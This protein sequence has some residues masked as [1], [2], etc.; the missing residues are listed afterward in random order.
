MPDIGTTV[1]EWFGTHTYHGPATSLAELVALKGRRRVSVVMPA[2]N[3]AATIG[4]IVGSV[5]SELST[6]GL[7]DEI[8]VV[9]SHSSDDTARIARDHG[10]TVVPTH[11][12]TEG[13]DDGKGG[14]LRTGIEQMSGDVAVLLDA[15]V[16][17]FGTDF[18]RGLLAPLLHDEQ[19]VLVKA[20]YDRPWDTGGESRDA[21]ARDASGG[22]R[23]TELVARP[24]IAQRTPELAG[25]VQPLSGECALVRESLSDQ[26][27]VSGY[28]VDIALLLQTV[29]THGLA[30]VAQADLGRRLHRHQDLDALGRMALQVSAAFDIVL[31]GTDVVEHERTTVRRDASGTVSLHGENV[32]TRRLPAPVLSAAPGPAP[33]AAPSAAPGPAP[34]AAPSAAP[35]PAPPPGPSAV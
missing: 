19:L 8:L 31:D 20:F 15:D 12:A 11:D 23:V 29:R 28:G 14:A 18:V 7:V 26:S 4:A 2:R 27:F 24:I 34:P 22:G 32:A 9:D 1:R 30:A 10:A 21:A 6:T 13:V 3:E 25:F 35:G 16:R 33:P 5:R 17:E